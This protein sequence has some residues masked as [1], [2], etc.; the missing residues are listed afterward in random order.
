MKEKTETISGLKFYTVA[1]AFQKTIRRGMESEALFYGTELMLSN[2]D[3]FAWFR[4]RVIM[5]EDI[6]IANPTLPAQ[7][8]ALYSAY[9]AMKAMKNRHAPER[10]PFV[11]AI[12]LLARSPKS[13]LVDNKL[14]QY[15][16]FRDKMETPEFPDFVFD[17]HTREGREMGRDFDHFFNESAQLVNIPAELAV[18]EKECHEL[19]KDLFVTREIEKFGVKDK[20]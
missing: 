17:K 3:E 7:I 4:M 19:V 18:E 10:L 12:M 16:S 1:S 13:R 2:Y 5:S 8:E 11:H 14:S 6:G 9:T 20:D 15:F